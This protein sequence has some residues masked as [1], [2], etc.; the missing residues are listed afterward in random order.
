MTQDELSQVVDRVMTNAKLEAC[1]ACDL[2]SDR[3]EERHRSDGPKLRAEW[4]DY[5]GF[6][7]CTLVADSLPLAAVAQV[8][9]H[10]QGTSCT[11]TFTPCQLT[12][13]P[14]EDLLYLSL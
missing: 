9:L 11:A 8:D 14:G 4:R 3:V 13:S 10:E 2:G 5:V 12:I 1:I 7:R 6:R